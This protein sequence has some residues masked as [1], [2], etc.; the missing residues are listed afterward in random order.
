MELS[1]STR[2]PPRKPNVIVIVIVNLIFMIMLCIFIFAIE[3]HTW[4]SVIVDLTTWPINWQVVRGQSMM[5]T[6]FSI[7]RCKTMHWR[8]ISHRSLPGSTSIT[9]KYEWMNDNDSFKWLC[10][11][12]YLYDKFC[13]LVTGLDYFQALPHGMA[14]SDNVSKVACCCTVGTQFWLICDEFREEYVP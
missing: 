13:N 6:P 5:E 7:F 3:E 8:T 12:L 10:N 2:T 4:F 9:L 11:N 14:A 1:F